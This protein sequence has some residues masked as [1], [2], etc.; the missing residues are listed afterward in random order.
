MQSL[1][2]LSSKRLPNAYG[3]DELVPVSAFKQLPPPKWVVKGIVPEGV[4]LIYSGYGEGK[5]FSA[6][7]LA[8]SLALGRRWYGYEIAERSPVVYVAA[9]RAAGIVKRIKA[10]EKHHGVTVPDTF[11]IRRTPVDL[12]NEKS[13]N[14]FIVQVRTAFPDGPRPKIIFDTLNRCSHGAEEN[15]NSHMGLIARNIDRI[16]EETR[17]NLVVIIHHTGK[18][19]RRGPRGANAI[20]AAVDTEIQ[21]KK[22]DDTVTVS[23]TKQ[24]DFDEFEPFKI[25]LVQIE[26]NNQDGFDE[27]TTSCVL[28]RDDKYSFRPGDK[29]QAILDALADDKGKTNAEL[30]MLM[31]PEKMAERTF[32]T[33]LRQLRTH[34]YVELDP[35]EGGLGA[36]YR[37]TTATTAKPLQ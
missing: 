29:H 7:G 35:P 17:A 11:M 34:G 20:G 1:V 36:I 37:L 15:S 25:R 30:K 32:D 22:S 28:V 3:R 16:R 14:A 26:L 13:V 19:K 6:L 24:S 10:Y 33:K 18:D 21:L 27:E 31:T 2:P 23:C 12:M 5:S 4:L 9:E 8:M